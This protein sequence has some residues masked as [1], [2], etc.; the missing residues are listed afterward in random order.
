MHTLHGQLTYGLSFGISFKP[1]VVLSTLSGR[2]S[3][4]KWICQASSSARHKAT[5]LAF[6]AGDSGAQVRFDM[7]SIPIGVNNHAS[8]CMA[9]DKRLFEDLRLD[10]AEQQVGGDQ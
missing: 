1:V 9:N 2:G 10:Q 5:C 3:I 6:Q 7:D 4:L 8:Q